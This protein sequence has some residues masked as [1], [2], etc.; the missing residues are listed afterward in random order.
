MRTFTE[1]AG[2]LGTEYVQIVVLHADESSLTV[3]TAG[4]DAR[5]L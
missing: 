4:Q 3:W 2:A 1:H 5:K